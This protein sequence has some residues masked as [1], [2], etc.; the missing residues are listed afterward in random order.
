MQSPIH[1]VPLH[2]RHDTAPALPLLRLAGICKSFAGVNALQ[3]VH[4]DVCAGEVHAVCGEN[5]AG[6][7]TLM[8]IMSGIYQPDAGTLSFSGEPTRFGSVQDAMARGVVMIHQELN[9]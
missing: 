9:L 1:V 7:S 8:K 3:D 5:G 2:A 6:K 4:F